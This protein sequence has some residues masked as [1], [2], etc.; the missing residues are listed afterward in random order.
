MTIAIKVENISKR[1]KI[2]L[3][4]QRFQ[5]GML[6]DVLVDTAKAPFR[7][8]ASLLG[9]QLEDPGRKA[10]YI[11][12][13]K[14]V[15]FELEEGKVL[16]IVG[17]NGAGKSTLLKVLSRVTEPTRGSVTVRGRVGSLLEVGT[18]F[19]PELTGRENIFLNGAILGMKRAEIAAKFDE[20]VEFSEVGQF[21]DTPV[22][23]YSSGMYLRLAFAVAAHLEPEILVVDE[24]LAV[25]DAEFQR[26]CLGKM[27]DVA[28]QGRTV[29]F[30]SHNMSAI[31]RLTQESIVMQKGQLVKRA[32]TPE[33]VD[34]YL[35]SGQAQAGERV[36]EADEVPA[37]AMPFTPLSLRVKDARG[38]V[39]DT[40]RSTEP[41]TLEMEYRLDAP[42]TGLRVGIYLSTVRGE[43]VFTSFDVDDPAL[44]EKFSARPA[45]HYISKCQIPADLLN[46]G[47][48]ILGVNASSFGVKRYFMD[49]NAL[50]F[51]I[52]PM[53]A[54]GMQWAEQRQGPVRPR[55][56]WVI[57]NAA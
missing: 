24:V 53:G 8:A 10:G 20:I 11:W 7:F 50:A 27:N 12:A 16:G 14:D 29:L 9:K 28:A 37:S 18:G 19:H 40:L 51:N 31:L 17:R 23:R 46:E 54:P 35:A 49:E 22:K 4:S 15:S 41:I 21:I 32:P 44:Y 5:Y 1:Y 6:R 45:G 30:V 47:R 48:Y 38:A 2:G 39:A 34:F 36:W 3:A 42:I 25:G 56:N 55:L 43:Y 13:L 57:E 52:D 33:A 26:K